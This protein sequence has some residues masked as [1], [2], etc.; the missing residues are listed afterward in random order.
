MIHCKMVA[1]KVNNMPL[2]CSKFFEHLQS[3]SNVNEMFDLCS[4]KPCV[5]SEHHH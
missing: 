1:Y 3:A 4:I 2:L 5:G